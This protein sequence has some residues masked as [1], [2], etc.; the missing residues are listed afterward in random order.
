MADW[1]R[2][3]RCAG[4]LG[5]VRV[6]FR[7]A[8]VSSFNYSI[9][10]F[11]GDEG[12]PDISPDGTQVAFNWSGEKRDNRDVYVMRIGDPRHIASPR[13][14]LTTAYRRGGQ[15]AAKSRS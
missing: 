10:S 11:P 9:T 4:R 12:L 3:C 14:R 1:W 2:R 6:V 15:M 13:I 8:D 5:F 7:R